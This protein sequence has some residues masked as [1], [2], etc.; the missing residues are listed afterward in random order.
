MTGRTRAL[1]RALHGRVEPGLSVLVAGLSRRLK[2]SVVSTRS[3]AFTA[4]AALRWTRVMWQ[5]Q[6]WRTNR[7]FG[8]P[9]LQWPTDLLILQELMHDVRPRVVI[10]TGT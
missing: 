6:L 8:V 1:L 2:L 3:P 9:I 10:E 7:W 4:D 5:N